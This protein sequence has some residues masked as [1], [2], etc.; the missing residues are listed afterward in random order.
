M[1][2]CVF[3]AGAVG[4]NLATR[5]IAANIADI[6]IV[7]RGAHL[8]AIR[9]RGLTLQTRGT[10]I[11]ARPAAATAN[12]AELSPQDLV[13]VTLKA[14]SVPEAADA[15][16]GLLAP[17][18]TALFVLNGIPWWWR[19]GQQGDGGT[20]KLLDPDGALWNRLGPQRVLGCT[21]YSTNKVAE[22]GLVVHSASDRWIIGEPDGSETPRLRST[23]DLFVRAGLKALASNDIRMDIW[24]KLARNVAFNPLTALTR[25]DTGRLAGDPAIYALGA[26]MIDELVAVASAMGWNLATTTN[27]IEIMEIARNSPV[28]RPSMLQ[29]VLQGRPTEVEAILGQVSAFGTEVGVPTPS[30]DFVLTVMR[31]LD[32]FLREG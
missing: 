26:A 5:L 7:A 32:R 14:A 10:E 8:E 11:N 16:A 1:K 24:T 31:G 23:V 6:S 17:E 15:I 21:V 28:G 9:T 3:G 19:Y 27:A 25:L 18:G 4:G 13:V 20:L 2:I 30:I 12:P 29:D 22:P